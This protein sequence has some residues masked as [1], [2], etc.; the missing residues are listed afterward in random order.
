M[1]VGSL[2]YVFITSVYD[3]LTYRLENYLK[4][5]DFDILKLGKRSFAIV[6]DSAAL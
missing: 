1:F 3:R 2:Q 5:Q 4:R 6:P